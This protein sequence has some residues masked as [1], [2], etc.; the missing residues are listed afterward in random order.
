MAKE[1]LNNLPLLRYVAAVAKGLRDSGWL[2]R[3]FPESP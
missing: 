3:G 1:A 2:T